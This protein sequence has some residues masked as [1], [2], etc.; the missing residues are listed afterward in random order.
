MTILDDYKVWSDKYGLVLPEGEDGNPVE[1]S[2]NGLR[3]TSDFIIA[4]Y[5]NKALTNDVKDYFTKIYESCEEKP[6]LMNRLPNW[7]ALEAIDDYIGCATASFFI[8]E[9]YLASKILEYPH[10]FPTSKLD[11]QFDGKP[12]VNKLI[13]Y[14]LYIFT[15]SKL[16]AVYNNQNPETFRLAAWLGRF[17]SL[18]AHL[19]LSCGKNPT[20]LEKLFWI[21]ALLLSLRKPPED[22]DA[23]ILSW[24]LS[25]VA[26]GQS[27][28][29][30]RVINYWR[31]KQREK[32]NGKWIAD[33]MNNPLLRKYLANSK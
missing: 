15:F 8:D 10:L 12:W 24:H 30:D 20:I 31:K 26:E 32:R 2:G 9:G 16:K 33:Y 28:L 17:P 19:K 29:L 7:P 5:D 25:R 23:F 11:T 14:I 3:Y 13:F 27:W 6:G 4:L 18:F 21:G 22:F 1:V